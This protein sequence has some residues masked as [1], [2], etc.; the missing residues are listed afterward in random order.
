MNEACPAVQ[1]PL[2][3]VLLMDLVPEDKARGLKTPVWDEYKRIINEA[4]GKQVGQLSFL[5]QFT[6]LLY[7]WLESCCSRPSKCSGVDLWIVCVLTDLNKA[8]Q[9]V[10]QGILY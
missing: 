8:L 6:T 3:Q 2:P 4:E 9:L 1:V 5:L 7:V 10:V